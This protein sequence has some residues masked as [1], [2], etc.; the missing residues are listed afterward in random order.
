MR[1]NSF[2]LKNQDLIPLMNNSFDGILSIL[3]K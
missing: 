2:K 3:K 1:L